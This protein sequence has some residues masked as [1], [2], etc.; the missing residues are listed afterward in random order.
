MTNRCLVSISKT[1][2]LLFFFVL[3]QFGRASAQKSMM[4]EVNFT[5]LNKL[6]LIA[7][8][9]YPRVHSLNE[10]VRVAQNNIQRTQLSWFE[11]LGLYYFYLP[12]QTNTGNNNLFLLNGFQLGLSLNLGTMLQKPAQ[13]RISR[14]QLQVAEL[15]KEEYLLNLDAQVKDRYFRYI[16]QGVLLKLRTQAVLDAETNVNSMR[17]RFERGQETLENLNRAQILMNEQQQERLEAEYQWMSAKGF[18]E[19]LLNKKLEEIN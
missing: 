15:Q 12:N 9:Y 14:S 11:A 8:E 19:E 10:Q 18:L 1:A 2:T 16:Q 13:V 6:I 7:R 17:N 4:E 3:L 5:Y